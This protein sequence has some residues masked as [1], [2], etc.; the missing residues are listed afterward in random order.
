MQC[1]AVLYEAVL[2]RAGGNTL[3]V[4]GQFY[5]MFVMSCCLTVQRGLVSKEIVLKQTQ[6][7][8]ETQT[9]GFDMLNWPP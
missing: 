6:N 8:G 5:V 4:Y 1:C 3:Y 9:F 7:S 2:C